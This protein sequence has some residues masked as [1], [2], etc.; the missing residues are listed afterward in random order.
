[1]EG[2]P[3]FF[4]FFCS[5]WNPAKFKNDPSQGHF[6]LLPF[7][8]SWSFCCCLKNTGLGSEID[9]GTQVLWC[10][11]SLLISQGGPKR[12]PSF[13]TRGPGAPTAVQADLCLSP[14]PPNERT[15]PFIWDTSKATLPLSHCGEWLSYYHFFQR[16]W[17]LYLLWGKLLSEQQCSVSVYGSLSPSRRAA[18]V[19]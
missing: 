10:D 4:H 9:T 18:A 8:K 16:G 15:L 12:Q 1:M 17:Y 14:P 2:K 6:S 7:S 19:P 5:I 13:L 11:T 3:I